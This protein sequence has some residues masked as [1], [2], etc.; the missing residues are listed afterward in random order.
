MS[1][2]PTIKHI[3]Q[4]VIKI[5]NENIKVIHSTNEIKNGFPIYYFTVKNYAE[6]SCVLNKFSI[7]IQSHT[8]K[9]PFGGAKELTPLAIWDVSYQEDGGAYKPARPIEIPSD[10]SCVIGIRFACLSSIG[11]K[12]FPPQKMAEYKFIVI[13]FD[14]RGNKA[15]SEQIKF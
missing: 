3:N 15:Q 12:Y 13:F 10:N 7:V 8:P 14:D 5:A 9:K 6:I 11:G 2:L 4:P 1:V